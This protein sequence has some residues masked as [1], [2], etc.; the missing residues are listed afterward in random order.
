MQ[1]LEIPHGASPVAGVV[2]VSSGVATLHP[3]SPGTVQGL[4][5]RADR[6]L[7]LAKHEGRNRV[8][9]L[10]D[11]DPPLPQPSR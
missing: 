7:Y 9:S 3:S 10:P 5:A 4:L 8:H 2:T 1:R 6:A 11:S